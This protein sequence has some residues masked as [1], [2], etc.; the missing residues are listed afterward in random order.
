MGAQ[1]KVNPDIPEC[2]R[3]KGWYETEGKDIKSKNLSQVSSMGN[4]QTPWMYLQEVQES[5]ITV[6]EKGIYFQ[7]L[8]TIMFVN[9]NAIYKACPLPDCNKKLV[10]HENGTYRCEKC[11]ENVTSFK[12]RLLM[13][14]G[15]IKHYNTE[16]YHLQNFFVII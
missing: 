10:D 7:V 3:L 12:Y 2:H 5:G 13:L 8:G 6:P 11:A 4:I 1:I 16:I 14:V 9:E 15:L